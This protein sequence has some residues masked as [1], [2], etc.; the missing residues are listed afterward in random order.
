MDEIILYSKNPLNALSELFSTPSNANTFK[1][2]LN[3]TESYTTPDTRKW[4]I[5]MQD[6]VNSPGSVIAGLIFYS[7]QTTLSNDRRVSGWPLI[8]SLANIACESQGEDE[9]HVLL[10]ILPVIKFFPGTT[11]NFI[12]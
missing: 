5:A 12:L 8:M 2:W 6:H 10:A 11:Y 9:G 3:Y 7:D 1:L 4:W